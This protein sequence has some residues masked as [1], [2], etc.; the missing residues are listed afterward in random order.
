MV[1]DEINIDKV[2][3]DI[4]Q[5]KWSII[6]TVKTY[7][8]R[9]KPENS[10]EMGKIFEEH[11]NE[12]LSQE[13]GKDIS[14]F[15]KL[16]A[17]KNIFPSA[18]AAVMEQGELFDS[19][20]EVVDSLFKNKIDR[21]ERILRGEIPNIEKSGPILPGSDDSFKL[22][23]YCDVC[24]KFSEISLEEQKEILNSE[25][26][27]QLPNCSIC[28]K[29]LYIH[30]TELG[31]KMR[32]HVKKRETKWQNLPV[33]KST[34][35]YMTILSVGIDVGSSTSHLVFSRLH[36]KRESGFKNITNRFSIFN[37]EIIYEGAI[38]DTPL[39]DRYTIDIESLI[40]FFKSEYEKA[41]ITQE[42]VDTGAVIVTGE[43]AKKNNAEE[44]VKQLASK[45]GKF[46]SATAGPNLE[47][48]LAAKGSG[49]VALS[50]KKGNTILHVD[51]GGGTSNLAIVSS[52]KIV[53]TACI[54]IG[55][56]LLGI[57]EELRIWRIDEPS[58]F[59]LK[60]LQMDYELG[61]VIAQEDVR[62][63]AQEYAKALIEVMTGPPRSRV[64]KE[65]MM[66]EELDYST[67]I[68]EYS[69]SGGVGELI[70]GTTNNNVDYKD[71]GVYLAEEI[72]ILV[73]KL[74]LKIL[75]PR[76]KIR[77][78]VIGAGSFSLQVSGSTC[79]WDN[80]IKFPLENIPVLYVDLEKENF[81]RERVLKEVRKAYRKFDIQEGDEIV[82]LYMKDPIYR[83]EYYL[84]E[85]TTAL[86]M[87]LPNTVKNKQLIVF[88]FQQDIG[89]S[90]GL[91][92]KR[93]TELQTNF[94]CIDELSLKEGDWI[95]IGA[96]LY[97]GKVIPITAKSL[98][99]DK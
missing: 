32:K 39:L 78:T 64:T 21:V 88:V 6:E 49:I 27:L 48:V 95:D 22:K 73:K 91:K 89:G 79:F 18:L 94:M 99:F 86:S 59:L 69:F 76:Q 38:I 3:I 90:V 83:N 93:D 55:G 19:I 96:P 35:S 61:D 12:L 4:E 77:A 65:L 68:D 2:K 34:V 25:K 24:K 50:E 66:T 40:K 63:L 92:L 75:E 71:I 26:E 53:S 82:A 5:V 51:I 42:M 87:A 52:G 8:H 45:T 80:N 57:D 67:P 29:K 20:N 30:I 44:I 62:M 11:F 56:R 14:D 74:R 47:S 31:K 84:E 97:S 28:N 81:S 43:T 10:V 98:I 37:R 23:Y 7:F 70:Y 60:E 17:F 46:V 36:F 13:N 15:S 41:G 33:K 58:E 85:F 1:I 72:N 9:F 16:V 54:N